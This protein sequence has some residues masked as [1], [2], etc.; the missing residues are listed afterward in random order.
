M[1]HNDR[2]FW[3]WVTVVVAAGLL[4]VALFVWRMLHWWTVLG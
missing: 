2:E 4:S 3:F 1:P